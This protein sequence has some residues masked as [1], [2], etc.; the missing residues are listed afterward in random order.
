MLHGGSLSSV[1]E[2]IILT[3]LVGVG[4]AAADRRQPCP[5]PDHAAI[6]LVDV[7]RLQLSKPLRLHRLSQELNPPREEAHRPWTNL[8]ISCR[9]PRAFVL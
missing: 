6:D 5:G 8:V 9:S 2:G 4:N 1:K 3:N 7:P